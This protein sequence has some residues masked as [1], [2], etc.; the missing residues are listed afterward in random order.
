MKRYMPNREIKWAFN[1]WVSGVSDD[2]TTSGFGYAVDFDVY[3][4]SLGATL[5]K[6]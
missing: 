2:S 4:S 3:V 5:R 6:V 1:L